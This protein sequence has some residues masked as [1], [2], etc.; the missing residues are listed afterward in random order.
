M[1]TSHEVEFLSAR[2]VGIRNSLGL[3]AITVETT[4]V[5]AIKLD[6]I[7]FSE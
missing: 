6:F 7:K 1:Q 3:R 2:V 5:A 4:V